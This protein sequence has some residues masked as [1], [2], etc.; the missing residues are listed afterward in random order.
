[1]TSRERFLAAIHCVPT[2]RRFRYEHGPGPSTQAR[3]EQEG[4]PRDAL[5]LRQTDAMQY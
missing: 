1:M 4:Y 5:H 2:D 3:W